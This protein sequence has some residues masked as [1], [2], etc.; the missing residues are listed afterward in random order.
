MRS[1]NRGGKYKW[2]EIYIK[3]KGNI[4]AGIQGEQ[5]KKKI[6]KKRGRQI[7]VR[8]NLYVG[9]KGGRKKKRE[10]GKKQENIHV[11]W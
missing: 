9:T 1:T 11:L 10:V 3:I 2:K 8:K 5:K 6:R 7:Y 4:D